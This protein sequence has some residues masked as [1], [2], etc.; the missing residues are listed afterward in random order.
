MIGQRMRPIYTQRSC[1]AIHR[2]EWSLT[3][4]WRQP[5]PSPTW[6]KPLIDRVHTD[7]ITLHGHRF[8]DEDTSQFHLSTVP[9][10]NPQAMTR[11]VKGRLQHLVRDDLP[12]A[13]K[14]NYA[15]RS[16]G[17]VRRDVIENYVS[18]QLD[19]HRMAD[20]RVQKRLERYQLLN[21]DVVL[22]APGVGSHSRYWYNLHVVLVNDGRWMEIRDDTL[23]AIRDAV[24]ATSEKWG[25]RIARAGILPDHLH[26]VLGCPSGMS[27]QGV[28]LSYMNNCAYA[29]GMKPVFR[30][31][32]YVGTFGEYDTGVFRGQ[33]SSHRD[34]PGGDEP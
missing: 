32:F 21:D 14:R 13:F 27:P 9:S 31:S 24:V 15:V 11:S 1:A 12:K 7:G 6:L 10:M 29:L 18:S 22:A 20:A 5:A 17:S 34:K 4:F 28:A 25:H 19:H 8:V 33:S 23:S 26:L 3:L 30:A 16:V 2:L